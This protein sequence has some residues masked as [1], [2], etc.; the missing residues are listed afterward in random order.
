MRSKPSFLV[1]KT[2]LMRKYWPGII[3]TEEERERMP[4]LVG[5]REKNSVAG[6]VNVVWRYRLGSDSVNGETVGGIAASTWGG[7]DIYPALSIWEGGVIAL[8]F[9]LLYVPL[10][11]G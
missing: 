11:R 3:V 10:K 1:K 5:T 4:P 9:L 8:S 2:V 6:M 7:H